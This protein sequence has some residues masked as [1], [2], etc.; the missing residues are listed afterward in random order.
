M[1]RIGGVKPLMRFG[2]DCVFK[3]KFSY[4]KNQLKL[5]NKAIFDNLPKRKE[6]FLQIIQ[7]FDKQ[8]AT[9]GLFEELRSD[10]NHAK[11]EF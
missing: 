8:E 5:W 1:L 4:L 10:S 9:T 11:D 7:D 6:D 2:Q 3:D